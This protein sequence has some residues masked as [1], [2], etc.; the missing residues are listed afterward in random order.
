MQR[1]RL[2]TSART[3]PRDCRARRGPSPGE[4][5]HFKYPG[6]RGRADPGSSCCRRRDALRGRDELPVAS[7]LAALRARNATIGLTLILDA[8]E[9]RS[10]RTVKDRTLTIPAYGLA[11]G[12]AQDSKHPAASPRTA[13]HFFVGEPDT[14]RARAV[15]H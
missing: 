1:R 11:S 4:A 13:I 15:E 10:S 7:F 14:P 2:P 9:R 12:L 8:R 5:G 3:R 6:L